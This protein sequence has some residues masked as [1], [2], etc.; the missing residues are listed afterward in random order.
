MGQRVRTTA[1]LAGFVTVLSLMVLTEGQQKTRYNL[2]VLILENVTPSSAE[3][4]YRNF[5]NCTVHYPN[6]VTDQLELVVTLTKIP[7]DHLSPRGVL[8][9]FCNL[10][11]VV[12]TVVLI[13]PN[14]NSYQFLPIYKYVLNHLS[15]LGIPLIVWNGYMPRAS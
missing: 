6:T 3:A 8:E 4:K 15:S 10:K 13:L 11:G 9:A 12:S 5:A 7:R 2:A 1:V 14:G